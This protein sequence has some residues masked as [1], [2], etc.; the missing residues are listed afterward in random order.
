MHHKTAKETVIEEC[1]RIETLLLALAEAAGRRFH[2]PLDEPDFE[3][4]DGPD[5][6]WGLRRLRIHCERVA[7]F[8]EGIDADLD[9]ALHKISMEN[10]RANPREA[11]PAM[12]Q[13]N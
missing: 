12:F 8:T 5:Y 7:Q 11:R 4:T 9:A 10:I 1:R 3:S 2:A 6:A 13:V